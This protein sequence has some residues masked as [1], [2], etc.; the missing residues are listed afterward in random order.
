MGGSQAEFRPFL[1]HFRGSQAGF[2]PFIAHFRGSQAGF[3]PFIAHFR[4]SQAGFRPIWR[5][6]GNPGLDLGLFLAPE[7]RC[8]HI[9]GV[10]GSQA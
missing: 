6:E 1:A 2:R 8:G 3:R 9:W 5:I 10:G 7:A 4:G